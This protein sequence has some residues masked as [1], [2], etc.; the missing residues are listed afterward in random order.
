MTGLTTSPEYVNAG[1]LITWTGQ[2]GSFLLSKGASDLI[3]TVGAYLKNNYNLMV[4]SSS[5][6]ISGYGLGSGSITLYLM[7]A[8]D[9]G[10]GETDDGLTDILNNV[11]DAFSNSG[12][13]VV[14]SALTSYTPASQDGSVATSTTVA[15]QSTAVQNAAAAALLPAPSSSGSPTDWF[16]QLQSNLESGGIGLIIGAAAV[17][18]LVIYISIPKAV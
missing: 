9:R 4:Q 15:N 5:N 3:A 14:S 12:D 18:G 11:N 1:S 17:V 10:D 13:A 8:I 7:T 16:S 2:F 6:N